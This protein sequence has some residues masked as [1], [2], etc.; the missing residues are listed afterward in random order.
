MQQRQEATTENVKRAIRN[1]MKRLFGEGQAEK[2]ARESGFVQRLR[3]L[4]P[5]DLL[6]SLL[7]TLGSRETVAL[8]EIH[9]TYQ[10]MTGSS[11]EYKP[12]H[13][14]LRKEGFAEWMRGIFE[15]AMSIFDIVTLEPRVKS[16]LSQFSDIL[17]HDGTSMGVHFGLA[18]DYPG[19]FTTVTPAAIEIHV[20]MSGKTGVPTD[21]RLAPDADSEHDYRPD[22]QRLKNKLVLLDR[23]YEDHAY[24]AEISGNGGSYVVRGK[25]SGKPLIVEARDSSGNR[26]RKLEGKRLTNKILPRYDVDLV[27]RFNKRTID[28]RVVVLYNG[29]KERK[30]VFTRLYTNLDQVTFSTVD[31][32][33]IYRFR[34]QIE[35]LFKEFKSH[36]SL[37]KFNTA[38]PAI[39]EGLVWGSLLVAILKRAL[40]SGTER[41]RRVVIST[42]KVAKSP[43]TYLGILVAALRTNTRK[44]IDSALRNIFD[45]LAATAQ[46]ANL[47]RDRTTGR[48][49]IPVEPVFTQS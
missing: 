34:W 23:G 8:A 19:R 11:I 46:R 13:N 14:Q 26:L 28:E 39:M 21:A 3:E 47:H 29:M 44:A 1:G 5:S 41:T 49:S 4:Q 31:V 37:R 32:G 16:K 20:T 48:Y 40:A 45:I 36:A 22:P 10:A 38:M 9:R 25:T 17:V 24:F 27:L 30:K 2:S 15:K 7:T 6:L 42:L 12:F 43:D 18:E 35:L 33:Q